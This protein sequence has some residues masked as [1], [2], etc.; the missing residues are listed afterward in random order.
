MV[1]MVSVA[2]TSEVVNACPIRC[3]SVGDRNLF[4]LTFRIAFDVLARIG[5]LVPYPPGLG[6][7]H[8]LRQDAEG[9]VCLTGDMRQGAVQLSNVGRR[10]GASALLAKKR[11]EEHRPAVDTQL[12]LKACSERG[13]LFEK[14]PSQF[15]HPDISRG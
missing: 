12:A 9:A 2:P 6:K 4:A 14:P 13:L 15:L 3:S 8:H 5:V 1:Y 10:Y 7:I 11:I